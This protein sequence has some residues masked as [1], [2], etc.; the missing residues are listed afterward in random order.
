MAL[1][2]SPALADPWAL[3]QALMENQEGR[4]E[5][6]APDMA[7]HLPAFT[8]EPSG[9]RERGWRLSSEPSFP[10]KPLSL[11]VLA[12]PSSSHALLQLP[13]TDP[14]GPGRPGKS[15]LPSLSN[16]SWGQGNKAKAQAILWSLSSARSQ[17]VSGQASCPAASPSVSLTVLSASSLSHCPDFSFLGAHTPPFLY[18]FS[19]CHVS[20]HPSVLTQVCE[21]VEKGSQC[22]CVG[23]IPSLEALG[24]RRN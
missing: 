10:Q 21:Q 5:H 22:V 3:A 20:R 4:R 19:S 2:L 11:F 23:R 9:R 8:P 13:S 15:P 16:F 1:T 14:K 24:L 18:L 17:R 7:V 6:A 12:P